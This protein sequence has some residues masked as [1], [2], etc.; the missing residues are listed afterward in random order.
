LTQAQVASWWTKAGLTEGLASKSNS[1]IRLSRGKPREV[2]HPARRPRH[3]KT[4]PR[5]FRAAPGTGKSHLLIGLGTAAAEAGYRVRYTLASKLVNELVEAADDKQLSK[6]I[7]R[8]GCVDLL[9]LDELGY[10][11]S[12]ASAPNCS[13]RY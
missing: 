5:W 13:S 10:M 7:T 1:S 8:Y 2:A 9:C 11:D 4:I 6:T 12:I 3:S